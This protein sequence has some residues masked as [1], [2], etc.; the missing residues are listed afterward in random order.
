MTY[1][2]TSPCSGVDGNAQG[3][4]SRAFQALT[5]SDSL[6][7]Q[8]QDER[9]LAPQPAHHRPFTEEAAM[10]GAELVAALREDQAMPDDCA[11]NWHVIVQD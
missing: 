5:C 3:L 7:A 8:T 2:R 10:I 6:C 1:Q 9:R 11:A 4:L